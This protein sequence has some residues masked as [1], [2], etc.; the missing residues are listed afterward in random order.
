MHVRVCVLLFT[1]LTQR[2]L[3]NRLAGCYLVESLNDLTNLLAALI[4]LLGSFTP[5]MTWWALANLLQLIFTLEF[6]IDVW[7]WFDISVM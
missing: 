3:V 5:L 7:L 1:R 6:T 4:S 2:K